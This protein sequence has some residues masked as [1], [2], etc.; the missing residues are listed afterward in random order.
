MQT[1]QVN[2]SDSPVSADTGSA[3]KEAQSPAS[4]PL[5]A[6]TARL[7]TLLQDCQ[8]LPQIA[9]T[10]MAH[11]AK[12]LPASI[13][14][15]DY[16]DGDRTRME[17]ISHPSISADVA[18][19]FCERWMESLAVEVQTDTGHSVKTKAYKR[20]NQTMYV[21][22]APIMDHTSGLAE[23]ALT[24]MIMGRPASVDVTMTQ[25]DAM[26]SVASMRI[27]ELSATQHA[28]RLQPTVQDKAENPKGSNANSDA[29]LGKIASNKSPK[30]FAFSIVNSI[31]PQL[32]AEQVGFGMREGNRIR[33]LAISGLADFKAASPGVALMQQSMEECLDHGSVILQQ[34]GAVHADGT[35][36]AIHRRWSSETGGANLLSIPLSDAAGAVAIMSVRRPGIRPFTKEEI[37]G[38]MQLL[39]PYGAALRVLEKA[40]RPLKQQMKG[41]AK[42]SLRRIFGP[43]T[44]GRKI[45]LGVML[46]GSLWC[47]FGTLT[48]KPLCAARVVS[49]HMLQMTSS[50]DAKLLAV[51]VQPGEQVKSG[52]LL[53]EFDTTDLALQLQA[54][55]RDITSSEVEVRRAVEA[56]DTSA[57]AL[58]KARVGV[59]ITQAASI[60]QRMESARL[61]A[62]ADGMIVRAD[63]DKRIGQIFALGSP[64][65]EFAPNGGWTLEIQIPDDIGTLV[66]PHQ[67]GT[68]AAASLTSHSM[69]FEIVSVDGTA[70][71]VDGK[72]VF[73]A[74]APLGE[75]PEWMKSGME[76]TAKVTTVSKPVWW[77]ALH[78]LVDWCRLSF[79]I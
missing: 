49:E 50:F 29:V 11:T 3:S 71:V 22:A 63:I 44:T 34:P 45:G 38:L 53:V 48:Y 5:S 69:P 76:G 65:I 62:P 17:F 23:G 20:E 58:A 70:Q 6:L 35:Q 32:G 13:T 72:N 74:R 67:V 25:I 27:A 61:V 41:A 64:V 73:I 2:P 51:H 14:R 16:R 42:D 12:H 1:P 15:V 79:W 57:A 31:A 37:A 10:L 26:A 36:F 4:L 56:R 55:E 18:K 21:F 7:R 52:Q 30:E 66:R 24:L 40:S 19:K 75:Q 54:L 9:Q 68:F 28:L 43:S 39:Q 8:S 33:V 60:Q 47:V 77:V 59:L 46:L 78:R